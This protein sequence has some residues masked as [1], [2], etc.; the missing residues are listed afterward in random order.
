M[1]EHGATVGIVANPASGRDIRRLVAQA[2]VFP[3]AEKANMVQ[4]VLAACGAIGVR[5]AVLSVD[6][7]GISAA[8]VR[9]L[10]L[11]RP[12]KHGPWP[13]IEFCE[14]LELTDSAEDTTN[15][16]RRM[17]EAGAGAIL[18]LGGDGTARVAAAACGDVPLLALSTGTNNAF[19]RIREAT[20]AGMAVALVATGA[21]EPARGTAR[22][23]VLEVRAAG[24][25]ELAL[26]DVCSSTEQHVGSRALWSP[27]SLAELHCTFAEPEGIGLSSVPGLLHPVARDDPRGVAVRF[28]APEDAETVVSAPVAPGLLRSVGVRDWWSVP[29]DEPVEVGRGCGVLALDGER[30]LELRDGRPASVA[31]RTD[32]PRC[33]DVPAVLA[34]AAEKGL[35][36]RERPALRDDRR[37]VRT[38]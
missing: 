10:R 7:G 12:A 25:R 17:V 23:K 15:A 32:G 11:R 18:C 31:L 34:E 13:E 28:A 6:L 27:A 22:A 1:G 37:E 35:L 26:V 14:D 24:R 8:L 3:T 16:V 20:V 9:A 19:P 2:S 29:P 33:V 4:R 36:R 5:R 21:V 30:E 38:P